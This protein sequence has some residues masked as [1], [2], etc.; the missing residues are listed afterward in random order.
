MPPRLIPRLRSEK[1]GLLRTTLQTKCEKQPPGAQEPRVC[2]Y[3]SGQWERPGPQAERNLREILQGKQLTKVT[4]R[5]RSGCGALQ[6]EIWGNS[7]RVS[8]LATPAD[9]ENNVK[10]KGSCGKRESSVPGAPQVLQNS[11]RWGGDGHAARRR[12]WLK[13]HEL[14][15]F[16]RWF[17]VL[18]GWYRS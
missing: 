18:L 10:L 12:R 4:F 2:V 9:P 7:L 13:A 3:S 14:L 5:E 15:G 11:F 17:T 1:L 6:T 16:Q 8:G